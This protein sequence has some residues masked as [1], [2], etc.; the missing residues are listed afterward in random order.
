MIDRAKPTKDDPERPYLFGPEIRLSL[1]S[2]GAKRNRGHALCRPTCWM[3]RERFPVQSARP[4]GGGRSPQE[5]VRSNGQGLA[6]PSRSLRN[7]WDLA[8]LGMA[9]QITSAMFTAKI[10]AEMGRSKKK[11]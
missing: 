10:E 7:A 5:G 4:E 8:W 3:I 2:S 6:A 1:D 9:I 11:E